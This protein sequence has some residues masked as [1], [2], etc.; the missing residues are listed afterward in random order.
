M[1]CEFSRP[2]PLTPS[3]ARRG[4]ARAHERSQKMALRYRL[5]TRQAIRVALSR[6]CAW[7]MASSARPTPS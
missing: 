4:G 2:H 1:Y 3:P 6:P 5:R 7:W